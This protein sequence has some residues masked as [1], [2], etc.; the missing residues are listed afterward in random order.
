MN[1]YSLRSIVGA[2]KV[3]FQM[4][5]PS[6][7]FNL[8][9]ARQQPY[10]EPTFEK[11]TFETE[12]PQVI[13]VSAVGATGKSTL[14]QVLANA[15]GLP[16]LDLAK[17]KPVGDNTL[18]GLLTGAFRVEDLSAIFHGLGNGTFGVIIDGVDEARSKTTEKAFEAFLDDVISLCESAPSTSFVLLGRTQILEDC[19]FYLET[20]TTVGLVTISPFDL[21]SARE[22]IDKFTGAAN[23]SAAKEYAEVRDGILAKLGAAFAH[24]TDDHAHS[25]LSFIGYPPVLDAIVALLSEEKNY[26]RLKGELDAEDLNDVEIAL[27]Y[28]IIAYILKRERDEKAIPNIVKPIIATLPEDDQ[29][30]ILTEI[31]NVEEQSFRLLSYCLG[32]QAQLAAIHEPVLNE[33]YEGQLAG[34]IAEHP[35]LVG[36]EFRSAVFEGAAIA[37]LLASKKPEYVKM[38]LAYAESHK[39]NYHLIYLLHHIAS[40]SVVPLACLHAIIGSAMEFHSTTTSVELHVDGPR[41]DALH[42]SSVDDVVETEVEVINR[43]DAESTRS[44]VFKSMFSRDVGVV[45]LGSRLTSTY[46]S[47]PCEVSLSGSPELELIAPVEI[48]ATKICLH[49]TSLVL[50]HMPSQTAD[51]HVLLE[52]DTL[53]S[54]LATIVTNGVD[55]AIAVADGAGIVFP[56]IQFVEHREP[57]PEDPTLQEKFLRLKRILVHFRSHGK[58]ALA[59]YRHKIEHARVLGTASGPAILDRLLRD[60][61]LT[62]DGAFYFL[63]PKNVDRH[64]GV[65][66][67]ALRKGHSSEKLRQYLRA[68]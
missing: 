54:S 38:A 61:I 40:D 52:S 68:I 29:A 6:D 30:S 42:A 22:Y 8:A 62:L 55:L 59:K 14:A 5:T 2:Q 36:C 16:L 20:K 66:W 34:W 11:V 46:V 48:S 18:T 27:I 64:L 35:F 43:T 31:Y 19:W 4:R 15:T 41:P 17:H 47:L 50:R 25:F 37:A 60:G 56:V 13:L 49:S 57:N 3:T 23:T 65:S 51:R 28:R 39:P 24:N 26:Y 44:F 9:P 33:Q 45:H 32:L 7:S 63:N 1:Y 10:I 12:R 58:G 53:E 67:D 21:D